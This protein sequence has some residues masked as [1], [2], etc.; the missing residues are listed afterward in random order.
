MNGNQVF[1]FALFDE[2]SLDNKQSCFSPRHLASLD[3]V[4][5]WP[6]LLSVFCTDPG[7]TGPS[8]AGYLTAGSMR[9]TLPD[10]PPPL[11]ADTQQ[12]WRFLTRGATTPTASDAAQPGKPVP[13]AS[14]LSG[15]L[16]PRDASTHYM[17]CRFTAG[18]MLCT[19][20]DALLQFDANLPHPPPPPQPPPLQVMLLEKG[21]HTHSTDAWFTLPRFDPSAFH[22]WGFWLSWQVLLHSWSSLW[23]GKWYDKAAFVN[24]VAG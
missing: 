20:S 12:E 14:T 9:S 17:W 2:E 4:W 23:Y 8:V 22:K 21:S 7:P 6:R 18:T 13:C 5:F 1:L 24:M 3:L 16:P 10:A 19:L 11:D 15:A